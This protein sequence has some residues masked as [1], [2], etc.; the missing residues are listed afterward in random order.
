MEWRGGH[1]ERSGS[2]HENGIMLR[3]IFPSSS[4]S[5]TYPHPIPR[6]RTL[7][8]PTMP[9]VIEEVCLR[10]FELTRIIIPAAVPGA[11]LMGFGPGNLGNRR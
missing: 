2:A 3:S 5:S 10:S 8:C 7:L 9:D 1:F 4:S 6:P 11:G